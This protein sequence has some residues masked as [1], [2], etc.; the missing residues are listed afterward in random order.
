[1]TGDVSR[2]SVELS[3][4]KGKLTSTP[5]QSADRR[6]FCGGA[7][8]LLAFWCSSRGR[9]CS[10]RGHLDPIV[11]TGLPRSGHAVARS[12]LAFSG[13]AQ[14]PRPLVAFERRA[15]AGHRHG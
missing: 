10:K 5:R 8:P 9:A 7:P 1:M 14:A 6:V 3:T 13:S 15:G 12:T 2:A 11:L 4:G